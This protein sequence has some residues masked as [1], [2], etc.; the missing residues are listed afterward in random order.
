MNSPSKSESPPPPTKSR[1]TRSETQNAERLK[2]D[3]EEAT[4]KEQ[5]RNNAREVVKKRKVAMM[6]EGVLMWAWKESANGEVGDLKY[7]RAWNASL[8]LTPE[9]K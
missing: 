1:S 7:S 4:K 5:R 3:K 6:N 2:L 8:Y 9:D